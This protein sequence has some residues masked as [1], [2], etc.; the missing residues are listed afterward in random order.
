MAADPD[1]PLP[2]DAAAT[3]LIR[4]LGAGLIREARTW[5]RWAG[6]G[7]VAGAVALGGVGA[8]VL[9]FSGFVW[10]ALSGAAVGGLGALLLYLVA[11]SESF[12]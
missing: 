5:G 12:L 9:G 4:A 7:A 6:V 3:A 2:E 11:S 1:P 8:F 10:G